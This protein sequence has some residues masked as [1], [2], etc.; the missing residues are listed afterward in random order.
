MEDLVRDTFRGI[1]IETSLVGD[2]GLRAGISIADIETF[3]SNASLEDAWKICAESSLADSCRIEIKTP[4]GDH[5]VGTSIADVDA[6][7][8]SASLEDG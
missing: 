6:L 5:G 3:G 1:G 2:G 4:L 7:G 8:G